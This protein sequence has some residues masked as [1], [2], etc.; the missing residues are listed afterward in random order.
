MR[1]IMHALYPLTWGALWLAYVL[2]EHACLWAYG[3]AR[4][5]TRQST[6]CSTAHAFQPCY[7]VDTRM[8]GSLQ[9]RSVVKFASALPL[10]RSR[11]H[12]DTAC[13]EWHHIYLKFRDQELDTSTKSIPEK[14]VLPPPASAPRGNPAE[15]APS[16][17]ASDNFLVFTASGRSTA[18]SSCRASGALLITLSTC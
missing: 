15:A 7:V 6:D 11:N 18:P 4:H 3:A 14:A 1:C 5:C 16:A 9:A 12:C 17:G 8:H 13:Q 10:Q 2:A